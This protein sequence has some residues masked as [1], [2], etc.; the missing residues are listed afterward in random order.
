MF[1]DYKEEYH[2]NDF[3]ETYEN[4]T[5]WQDNEKVDPD[6]DGLLSFDWIIQSPIHLKPAL[7]YAQK[8]PV[9]PLHYP[10][11]NGCSCGKSCDH[12]GKHPLTRDGY[13]SATTD[14]ELI[15]KW[16]TEHPKAG[17]G[18]PNGA[19]TF[20][21]LDIDV[22]GKSGMQSLEELEQRYGKL[23]LTHCVQSGS[24]GLH[25]Y[26]ICNLSLPR[27]IGLRPGIDFLGE[28]GYVIMP[29]SLHVKGS[30]Q[31]LDDH[32][33]AELPVW[34]IDLMDNSVG[35]R[36]VTLFKQGSS[37][38][39]SGL[40]LQEINQELSQLNQQFGQPL[41]Q[42]EVNQISRNICTRYP[43]GKPALTADF[44]LTEYLKHKHEKESQRDP[45][46][47]LGYRLN[48]FTEIERKL[49]GVQPGLYL[50]AAET[51]VGKTAFLVNLFLDL[52]E[53]N[54]LNGIFLSMDDSMDVI[55]NKIL[56]LKTGLSLNRLPKR[57]KDETDRL[58]LQEA[59]LNLQELA[60]KKRI[61]LF[62]QQFYRTFEQIEKLLEKQPSPFFLA[63]DG[64]FNVGVT[65][66][67]TKREENI[68][69]ANRLKAIADRYRIPV[70]GTAEVRKEYKTSKDRQLSL[71]DI[72]ES[73]KFAYNA[74]LVWLLSG[75]PQCLKLKYAKNKLS[76]FKNTQSLVY[77][78]KQGL[79]EEVNPYGI[80]MEIDE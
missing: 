68:E 9:F 62:D 56:G 1:Y 11:Y 66:Y 52:V 28:G 67:P 24:G 17:I 44:D 45:D 42:S 74:N 33:I 61:S 47:L 71:D 70:I 16:W 35:K 65:P 21:V 30:Y 31:S 15:M 22:D 14:P 75:E 8:W 29:P 78:P 19:Q 40:D 12:I 26:F 80:I 77:E 23:P 51:N 64:I 37:L 25:Y 59:Y 60:A 43:V 4:D 32:K 55:I 7:N 54:E 46:Q 53:S 5:V 50:I 72:M 48:R 58:K 63:I 2:E 38:R 41:D 10:F 69:R 57:Q 27:K 76:S 49:D 73:S 6:R 39:G 36:N 34:L 79:I 20:Y 18:I 13:K 3:D